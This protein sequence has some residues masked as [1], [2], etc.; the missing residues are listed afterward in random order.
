MTAVNSPGSLSV[1]LC[2]ACF[3]DN[4]RWREVCERNLRALVFESG[5]EVTILAGAQL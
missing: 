1:V 2:G 3:R 4:P 5:T